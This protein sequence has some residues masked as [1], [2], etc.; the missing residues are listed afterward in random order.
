MSALKFSHIHCCVQIYHVKGIFQI[1]VLGVDIWVQNFYWW[2]YDA[3][4]MLPCENQCFDKLFQALFS[5][6]KR[7]YLQNQLCWF[8]VGIYIQVRNRPEKFLWTSNYFDWRL[9]KQSELNKIAP[10]LTLHLL[11]SYTI[12]AMWF[13]RI[14]VKYFDASS[15]LHYL[16]VSQTVAHWAL[17]MVTGRSWA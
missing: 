11:L 10:I 2:K 5:P 12:I 8:I 7:L 13:C 1:L 17:S 9:Y 3:K 15:F 4:S 14:A 16:H 6:D